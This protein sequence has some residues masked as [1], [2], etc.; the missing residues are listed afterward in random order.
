MT[1]PAPHRPRVLVVEDDDDQRS[2]VSN[3]LRDRGY[4][5]T[6]ATDGVEALKSLRHDRTVDVVLLDLRLPNMDGWAFRVEQR[7]DEA[8]CDVP[9]VVMTADESIQARAIDADGMVK[10]PFDI[11][12][13]CGAL[14]HVL[15][16]RTGEA[17][18]TAARVSETVTLLVGAVGHEV[19]N[20]LMSLIGGLERTRE[21]AEGTGPVHQASHMNVD[22]MLDQCWRI[23][24]TLRT[25]RTLSCPPWSH[26]ET[27]DL[28]QTVRVAIAEASSDHVRIAF[29]GGD[30]ARVD[31]DPRVLLYICSSLIRNAVEAVPSAKRRELKDRGP[32]PEVAIRLHHS[33]DEAI[34]EVHDRGRS[35]PAEE[36]SKV[37]A[38]DTP[39]REQGWSVGLRLWFVRRLVESLGGTIGMSSDP[40]DG[41]RC[42]VRL[43][44]ARRES[45]DDSR[46]DGQ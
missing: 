6:E 23:A 46:L 26:E 19:A 30:R 21:H 12:A 38:V 5:V 43:P 2:T 40:D 34:L 36:L 29:D 17:R 1:R 44:T 15:A 24:G 28:A 45:H 35:I 42:E 14:R 18:R 7:R 8:L 13:L 31:A 10:K 41:V 37:F 25:L 22:Q 27:V 39:G 11:D 4:S 33:N 32:V 20:P 3:V 16:E 9:V